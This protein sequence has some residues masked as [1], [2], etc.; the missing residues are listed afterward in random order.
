MIVADLF[1]PNSFLYGHRPRS[2]IILAMGIRLK[3]EDQKDFRTAA[4]NLS[5]LGFV[6]LWPRNIH[7]ENNE[8][9]LENP[10]TFVDSFKYLEKIPRKLF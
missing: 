1:L 10:E 8:P 6:V 2:A 3:K 7:I 4:R 9:V 5:K